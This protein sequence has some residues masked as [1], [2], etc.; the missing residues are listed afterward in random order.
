MGLNARIFKFFLSLDALQ[1]EGSCTMTI[2]KQGLSLTILQTRH[3]RSHDKPG[4]AH[5]ILGRAQIADDRPLPRG[6]RRGAEAMLP[7]IAI[8]ARRPASLAAVHSATLAAV[9]RRGAARLAR[10]GARAAAWGG[11]EDFGL[12]GVFSVRLRGPDCLA[13]KAEQIKNN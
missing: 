8:A 11:G 6:V 9:D 3:L 2:V 12:H 5:H 7:G 1:R 4:S 13:Q 10:A